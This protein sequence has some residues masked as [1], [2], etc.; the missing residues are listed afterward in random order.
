MKNLP[1]P[2]S[3]A[4]FAYALSR[5]EV[6]ST[7]VSACAAVMR[8]QT[9]SRRK[10][11]LPRM[12]VSRC[13]ALMKNSSDPGRR[14]SVLL[15]NLSKTQTIQLFGTPMKNISRVRSGKQS[16]RGFLSGPPEFARVAVKLRPRR[17]TIYLTSTSERSSCLSLWPYATRATNVFIRNELRLNN[18]FQRTVNS[19]AFAV[20]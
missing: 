7:F 6:S 14:L 13:R 10:P 1:V 19:S 8:S 3:P 15:L 17:Y 4:N 5:A 9:Q 16:A 12:V 11:R 20:R 18:C 2:T